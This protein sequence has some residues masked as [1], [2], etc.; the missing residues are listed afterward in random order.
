MFRSV[1]NDTTSEGK[2]TVK[3]YEKLLNTPL[4]LPQV[5]NLARVRT[6]LADEFPYAA[7]VVDELLKGL[8]G[9]NHIHLRPTILVGIPGC[10]KLA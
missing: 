10:G 6:C 9:R 7:T 1:G 3:E 5:P 2:R 4:P 8:V